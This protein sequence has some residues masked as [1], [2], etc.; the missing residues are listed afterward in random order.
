MFEIDPSEVSKEDVETLSV[1][2]DSMNVDEDS[3]LGE[4]LQELVSMLNDGLEAPI[5]IHFKD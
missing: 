4:F 5:F 1:M 2:A 3:A